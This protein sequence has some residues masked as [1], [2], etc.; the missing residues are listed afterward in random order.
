[1][2]SKLKLTPE[3]TISTRDEAEAAITAYAQLAIDIKRT[4]ATVDAQV[5][6][7][8]DKFQ[9]TLDTLNRDLKTH[10]EALCDWAQTHPDEFPKGRK[11]L[12]FANGILGFRTGTPK[13]AL[14]SRSWNWDKVLAAIQGLLPAFVRSKPEVD[15]EALLGQ[16][17]ELAEFLPRVGLKVTQ[18]ETFFVE[19]NLTETETRQ[20]VDAA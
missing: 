10:A 6:A 9:G 14:I 15:K 11:S 16:R 12:E 13:L 8:R 4:T 18:D 19:P 20:T 2:R 17:D 3:L 7:I 5:T 1:M